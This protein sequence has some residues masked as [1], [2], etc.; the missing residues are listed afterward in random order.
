[1]I[2]N[3]L[4]RLTITISIINSQVPVFTVV[5]VYPADW[6]MVSLPVNWSGYNGNYLMFGNGVIEGT[7]FKFTTTYVPEQTMIPGVGYW[8]RFGGTEQDRTRT[9]VVEGE[10]E[11]TELTLNLNY[12]WNL[13]GGLSSDVDISDIIDPDSI[14]VPGTIF[15]F[16]GTYDWATILEPGKAY[17]VRALQAGQITL[18][19]I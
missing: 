2:N 5:T 14:I 8:L 15:S 12:G 16:N 6:N 10:H 13:I 11:L 17:W 4:N 18:S 3:Y 7:L 19:V 9:W 1:M